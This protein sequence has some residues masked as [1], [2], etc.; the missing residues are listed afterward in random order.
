MGELLRRWSTI[1]AELRFMTGDK[2][3][4][5]FGRPG[6]GVAPLL[7]RL[8][9]FGIEPSDEVSDQRIR[10]KMWAFVHSG[11]LTGEDEK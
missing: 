8:K 10:A 4:A 2:K 11:E 9:E 5:D 7:R 1:V 6:E 3:W